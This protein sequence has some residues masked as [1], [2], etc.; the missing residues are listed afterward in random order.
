VRGDLLPP[1]G[2]FPFCLPSLKLSLSF[3]ANRATRVQ[4]RI[5]QNMFVMACPEYSRVL[6]DADEEA[7]YRTTP[8]TVMQRLAALR[9]LYS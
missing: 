7:R 4:A 1:R 9:F 2:D 5:W 3:L 8:N 6:T